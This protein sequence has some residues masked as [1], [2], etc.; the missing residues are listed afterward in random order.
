MKK[1][2]IIIGILS[3]LVFASACSFINNELLGGDDKLSITKKNYLGKE[4]K[5]DGY[6]LEDISEYSL[7]DMDD[8]YIGS[9]FFYQNGIL[10]N[11]RSRKNSLKE[12][13]EQEEKYKNGSYYKDV[14]DSK[15]SW[16]LFEIEEKTIRFQRWYPSS[17]GPLK[18]YVREGTIINDTTFRITRSYR[19]VEEA[20]TE[21]R[22]KNE[23]YRFKKLSPKPDSTNVFVN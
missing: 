10:L 19:I 23:L 5:I 18:A 12:I 3:F 6:Y 7:E 17:G 20:K 11:G 2:I 8:A 1:T 4:L 9:Y 16:G 14:K 21:I 13:N 22:S 15:L